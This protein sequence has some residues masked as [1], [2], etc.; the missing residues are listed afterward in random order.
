ML[1]T[2]NMN[3]TF[4][5]EEKSARPRTETEPQPQPVAQ[6]VEAPMLTT[7]NDQPLEK[8]E[9]ETLKRNYAILESF[10]ESQQVSNKMQRTTDVNLICSDGVIPVHAA[11]LQ[12]VSPFFD[13]IFS[14]HGHH[15][16]D[17]HSVLLPDYTVSD[18][19]KVVELIYHGQTT[20]PSP[21]DG[22]TVKEILSYF[23]IKIS[24]IEMYQPE[25]GEELKQAKS[26]LTFPLQPA[27]PAEAKN[28]GREKV[29]G[30]KSENVAQRKN[31]RPRD[32]LKKIV[33]ESQTDSDSDYDIEGDENERRRAKRA[34]N[35]KK[36]TTDNRNHPSGSHTTIRGQNDNNT[37]KSKNPGT[38]EKSKVVSDSSEDEVDDL[39]DADMGWFLN[40]SKRC[41]YCGSQCKTAAAASICLTGHSRLRCYYCFKVVRNTEKLFQHFA[42]KHKQAGRENCLM[43]PFCEQTIPY[44][45]VSCHVI[46]MHLQNP[47][48][49]KNRND[50]NRRA[51]ATTAAGAS[52]QNYINLQNQTKEQQPS[53]SGT[54]NSASSS[55]KRK[56]PNDKDTTPNEDEVVPLNSTGHE[57]LK[58]D[59]HKNESD[60]D[61]EPEMLMLRDLRQTLQVES[62]LKGK[63]RVFTVKKQRQ[64][65]KSGPV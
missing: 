3:S 15:Y 44:K 8:P 50:G 35:T 33:S 32:T 42:K 10:S 65:K 16:F 22:E 36:H 52:L 20:I 63:I 24:S 25:G 4:V 59:K 23:E 11:I 64:L 21:Q 43:C 40:E 34:K 51:I 45:S 2:E 27:E 58:L 31:L 30:D 1:S 14:V 18:F 62:I 26:V 5:V 29:V 61:S 55:K 60:S 12:A 46:S 37:C 13:R 47:A 28:E 38:S 6:P 53:S 39:K 57:Q 19:K 17:I 41:Q 9:N 49:N 48:A 7:E 56:A 54:G